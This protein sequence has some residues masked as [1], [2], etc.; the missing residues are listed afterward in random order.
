MD[1]Q[2]CN[3]CAPFAKQSGCASVTGH[4]SERGRQAIRK[5]NQSIS[6]EDSSIDNSQAAAAARIPDRNA[7]DK[8]SLLNAKRVLLV[9]NI[10]AQADTRRHSAKMFQVKIPRNC[11]KQQT[12][13]RIYLIFLFINRT[14]RCC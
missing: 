3:Y 5:L 11:L 12:R 13:G 7:V 1:I 10:D 8:S 9:P 6:N 2:R 4:E 14:A